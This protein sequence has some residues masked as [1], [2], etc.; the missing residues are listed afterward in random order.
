MFEPK[1]Q[2]DLF[3]LPISP[4]RLRR[5]REMRGLTQSELASAVE[6]DQSY[7]TCLETGARHPSSAVLAAVA[8]V[9]S[10]PPTYFTQPL[11]AYLTGGTLRYRAKA[12]L[13]KRVATRIR[14]EAEHDL[15]IV[16]GLAERVNVIPVRLKCMTES[17]QQASAIFRGQLRLGPRAPVHHLI[18]HFEKLGGIVIALGAEEGFDAFAEWG[19]R[20]RDLP[21]IAI[22]DGVQPDRLRMNLAHEI[23]HLVLHKNSIISHRQAET[24]AFSFASSLLMPEAAVVR[25]LEAAQFD[26]VA[27]T[28]VKRRWGVSV[29]ALVRRGRDLKLIS[30]RHYRTLNARINKIGWKY[31]EP[32]SAE[33]FAERPLAVRRMAEIAFGVPLPFH[34]MEKEL[35]VPASELRRFFARYTGAQEAVV[36]RT[37][38]SISN[39]IQ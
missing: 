1:T 14:S 11:R 8:E 22:S 37:A 17:P 12:S 30:D 23:G 6:V 24:E 32:A 21:I 29:Q 38:R 9:L 18:R 13:G 27:L 31:Q 15:E 7:I 33:R 39:S 35:H 20:S 3:G 5:A 25:D 36:V 2:S 4:D 34:K 26:L 10:L 28:E 19:G 16:L